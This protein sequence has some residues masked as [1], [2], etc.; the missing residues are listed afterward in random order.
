MSSPTTVGRQP[1]II[2]EIDQDY[3]GRTFGVAPC[4]ATGNKCFNTYATC[5]AKNAYALGTPLTL[6]FCENNIGQPYD[7]Y[8]LMPFLESI[9][10]TPTRINPGGG[11]SNASPLGERASVTITLNDAPHTDNLVDPYLSTR[12][13]SP[14]ARSTFWRKW[15]ARNP[16]YSGRAIRIREGYLGQAWSAMQ[17]RHYIIDKISITGN[18]VTITGNDVLQLADDDKAVAPKPTDAKLIGDMSDAQTSCVTFGADL[19]D[20]PTAGTV[21]IGQ[22]CM[23]YT[24]RSYDSAS[25]R[26]TLNG[27][28]RGSDG[29]TVE[30]HSDRDAV[31]VCLRVSHQMPWVLIRDLLINYARIPT[32]YINTAEW[33]DE[34]DI[35]LSQFIVSRLITEPTGVA[36]LIGEICQQSL[37]YV[38]WDERAKLIKMRALRPFDDDAIPSINDSDNIIADSVKYSENTDARTSQVWVF[39]S[40]IN[41]TEAVDESKNYS[42]LRIRV[43]TNAESQYQFNDT[44][45]TKIYA[46]W[47]ETDAQAI[48]LAARYMGRYRSN[49]RMLSLRLDAKDRQIWTGSVAD[50]ETAHLVDETGNIKRMRFE[51]ISAHEPTSGEIIELELMGSEYDASAIIRYMYWMQTNVPTYSNATT[52]ER[53]RGFWW[54]DASGKMPDGTDGYVWQ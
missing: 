49:V 53:K 17:I 47:I 52:T 51:V 15:L 16:Y 3:C 7:S 27:L 50:V 32:S 9:E 19:V 14:L 20:F 12:S 36:Q 28:T 23:T 22:E 29:T 1:I 39:Y 10:T 24:S 18:G 25:G 6:R 44:R 48:N 13:Y 45:I 35:W 54:S 43:D 2:A 46:P 4:N 40:Q 26:I 41:P 11:D 34:G 31:Q 37:M 42:K 5:K 30:S 38:W 21:R 8:Y 33:N